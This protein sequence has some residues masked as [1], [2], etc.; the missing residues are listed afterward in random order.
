M[1]VAVADW[2]TT[3]AAV[4]PGSAALVLS[5]PPYNTTRNKWDCPIDMD[6]FF[7]LA[8]TALKPN[9]VVV[10]TT[11]EPFTSRAVI[12][13]GKAFKYCW[14]W[15]KKLPTG[16][17]NAKKQPL[18]VV[19]PVVVAYRATPTYN[20]VKTADP[21]G[22]RKWKRKNTKS[23]S[24]DSYKASEYNSNGQKYPTTL[25]GVYQAPSSKSHPTEKPVDLM[26]YFIKTY[27]SAGELVV[28]PFC[29]TGAT[30]VAAGR[31]GRQFSCGD[32]DAGYV[33]LAKKRSEL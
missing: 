8:W 9:G 3:L 25:L 22:A 33:Q 11:A 24:Y 31:L 23:G 4:P 2:K 17:L 5:D 15:D 18:R 6:E 30:A 29:G 13:A 20:P 26:G 7:K 10:I 1:S 27:T 28:D 19:E 16:H 21:A 32:I 12:A 14:Y